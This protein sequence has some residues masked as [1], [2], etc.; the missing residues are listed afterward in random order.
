MTAAATTLRD[1]ISTEW[2]LTGELNKVSE[3]DGPTLM[4]EVVQ[5][6]DRLQ[7]IGNEVTKAIVV[8]KINAE[9]GKH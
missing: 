5:F 8:E 9:L 1:I 2:A 6:F 4:D 7:V 3:G